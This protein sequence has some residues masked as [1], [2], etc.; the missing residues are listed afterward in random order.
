MPSP[1]ILRD[2]SGL[3]AGISS[4]GSALGEALS[5]RIKTQREKQEKLEKETKQNTILAETIGTLDENSSPIDFL[6][7]SQLAISRGVPVESVVTQAKLYEPY[8]KQKLEDSSN[9]GFLQKLGLMPEKQPQSGGQQG[10]PG[11]GPMPAGLQDAPGISR[12]PSGVQYT[13]AQKPADAQKVNNPISSWT[14]DMLVTAQASGNKRLTNMA[15]SEMNRR[16]LEQDRSFAE[17]KFHT[18]GT[19]DIKKKISTVRESV[20]RKKMALTMS[21]D[22][23][24]SGNIGSLSWA[25][26]AERTGFKELQSAK[27]SQLAT[28]SKENLLSNMSRVSARAQNQWFEQRLSS[29]FPQ[30]GQSQAANLTAQVMIE[31]ELEMEENFLNTYE[32][33]AQEDKEKYGYVREDIEDRIY[34]ELSGKDDDILNKAMYRTRQI[35]EDELGSSELEKMADKKVP[36]GTPLTP[37]MA[38]IMT[39]KYDQSFDRTIENAKKLGYRIPTKEEFRRW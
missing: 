2:L 33:L 34:K 15:T 13:T 30:V 8:L 6:K 20:P 9:E 1:I 17:R 36:S 3:G 39:K 4:A 38:K 14:D 35:Y 37:Y 23:I 31:S 25:N 24:E 18:E 16:K 7:Q 22:A 19:K 27:G 29:M 26:L 12:T 21:R 10:I 28:A 11:L 32:R 5:T